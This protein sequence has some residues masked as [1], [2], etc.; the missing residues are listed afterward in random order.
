MLFG[1]FFCGCFRV[2]SGVFLV[3]LRC[4]CWV[5]GR[6]FAAVLWFWWDLRF[7]VVVFGHFPVA[8][9]SFFG[10]F[11]VALQL[12]SCDVFPC[13]NGIS[14]S[15]FVLFGP[16]HGLFKLPK[17]YVLKGK[18]PFSGWPSKRAQTIFEKSLQKRLYRPIVGVPQHVLQNRLKTGHFR[19]KTIEREIHAETLVLT[20]YS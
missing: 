9:R 10:R 11:S 17:H 8:L 18:W 16:E 1:V 5:F 3:V 20:C 2:F 19:V 15:P 12:R 7:Q 13:F 6:F 4:F 14:H